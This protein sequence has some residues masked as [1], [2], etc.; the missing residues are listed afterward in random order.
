MLGTAAENPVTVALGLILIPK[1]TNLLVQGEVPEIPGLRYAW[2]S[3]EATLRLTYSGL[4]GSRDVNAILGPDNLFHDGDKTVARLLPDGTLVIDPAEVSSDLADKDGPNLCPKPE[5]DKAGR[6]ELLGA[7]DKDYEDQIKQ[8]VNPDN[9]TPRGYGYKFWDPQGE[10]WVFIDDCQHRTG[11]RVEIKSEYDGLLSFDR[12]EDNIR[13]D[14]LD[15]SARQLNVSVGFSLLWIFAQKN[16]RDYARNL[17]V[18]AGKGRER[19][20]T[21]TI[22]RATQR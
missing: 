14:W 15:Q 3:D 7:K 11:A 19:I 21:E 22:P 13:R 17:F 8:L 1:T 2:N 20:I 10:N 5:V 12:G 18:G 6:G 16:S 4:N 9:P